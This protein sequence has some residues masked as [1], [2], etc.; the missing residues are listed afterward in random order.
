MTRLIIPSEQT[1][2]PTGA[3]GACPLHPCCSGPDPVLLTGSSPELDGTV[4]QV[5][6][7]T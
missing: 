7:L 2:R 3:A 6:D 5:E 1:P 4:V